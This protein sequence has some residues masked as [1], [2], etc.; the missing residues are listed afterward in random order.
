[1][2]CSQLVTRAMLNDQLSEVMN[3]V[4]AAAPSNDTEKLMTITN[5]WVLGMT[6]H[7]LTSSSRSGSLP[8][9]STSTSPK[10]GYYDDVSISEFE[11]IPKQDEKVIDIESYAIFQYPAR[12]CGPIPK[13]VKS[14]K[15]W[16]KTLFVLPKLAARKMSFH[17]VLIE[18]LSDP[19]IM[20]YLAWL[21]KTFHVESEKP[22]AGKATDFVAFMGA[23]GFKPQM[24]YEMMCT[25]T[26]RK[27]VVDYRDSTAWEQ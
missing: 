9:S 25:A 26:A 13:E 2:T 17:Q 6:G 11:V 27:F 19:E 8:Q 16:S 18:S 21:D 23:C 22:T 15:V 1:M 10:R 4:I 5:A 7:L 24:R 12:P 20:K 14:L 3:P